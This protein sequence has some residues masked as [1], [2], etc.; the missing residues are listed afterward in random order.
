M[1]VSA[2]EKYCRNVEEKGYFLCGAIFLRQKLCILKC[3]AIYLEECDS[4][5]RGFKCILTDSGFASQLSRFSRLKK[6]FLFVGSLYLWFQFV[7]LYLGGRK[8]FQNEGLLFTCGLFI[9][10]KVLSLLFLFSSCIL[11][12]YRVLDP[13]ATNT[14]ESASL[15]MI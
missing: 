3:I 15:L 6:G 7:S 4:I 12:C 5:F 2:F 10:K 8:Y 9:N 1:C 14:S 13:Y 11:K